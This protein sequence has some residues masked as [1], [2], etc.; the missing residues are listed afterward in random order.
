MI[1]VL[2]DQPGL[3]LRINRIAYYFVYGAFRLA[4]F[5]RFYLFV[6]VSFSSLFL[7]ISGSISLYEHTTFFPQDS[8]VQNSFRQT[9]KLI[10]RYRDFPYTPCPHACIISSTI[11]THWSGMFVTKGEPALTNHNHSK[12]RVTQRF[13]V[14]AMCSIDLD[15]CMTCFHPYRI[16]QSLVTA[17]FSPS[18]V[19]CLL[20]FSPAPSNPLQP[21]MFLLYPQLHL[22]N[23]Y[24]LWDIICNVSLLI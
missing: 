24:I 10:G 18:A 2:V 11:I 16:I 19:L 3:G 7:L 9:V 15:K 22:W 21:M 4:Y 17:L 13:T 5:L 20:T 8:I 12:S 1:F 6:V 23:E 14:G